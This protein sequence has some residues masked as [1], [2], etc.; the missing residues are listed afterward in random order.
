[1]T[2]LWW[3]L[4]G[5]AVMDFSLQTEPM[6]RGKN[7]HRQPSEALMGALRA[8]GSQTPPRA[9]LQPSWAYWLTAHALH[10]GGAVAL[11]TGRLDLGLAEAVAHWGIDFGKC[12]GWY[13][14]HVD[15]ALHIT[16]KL[17]WWWWIAMVA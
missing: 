1:M 16:C 2:E 10:H 15:Q 17:M 3:M 14:I 9:S 13:N 11:A 6:A 12:E 4:V 8:G 5:H 7:R